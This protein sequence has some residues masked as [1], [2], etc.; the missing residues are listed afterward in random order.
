MREA[1]EKARDLVREAGALVRAM[2]EGIRPRDKGA[3]KGPVT[4]ADLA[5]ERLI[6]ETKRSQHLQRSLP[7][8]IAI[9]MAHRR[10]GDA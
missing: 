5:S 3:G 4:E 6:G 8:C 2:Q 7:K 1:A 10:F 9:G